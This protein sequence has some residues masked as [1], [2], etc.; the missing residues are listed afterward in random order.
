MSLLPFVNIEKL[1]ATHLNGG[2]GVPKALPAPYRAVTDLP[3]PLE[4]RLPLVRLIAGTS[5]R[6]DQVSVY[7]RVD[8]HC[9]AATRDAMWTLTE[10][11]VA[12]MDKLTSVNG[13]DV[14]YVRTVIYPYF[15]AW[16]PSVPRSIATYEIELR[17]R[18]AVG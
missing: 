3:D 12:A 18:R 6:D 4:P 8:V 9:F 15:L 14:D 17:P 7:P 2:T 11:M 5:T 1:V 10:A 13:Q 16:S